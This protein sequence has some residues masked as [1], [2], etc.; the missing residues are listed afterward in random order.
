MK[1][2]ISQPRP[3]SEKQHREPARIWVWSKLWGPYWG[4]HA[5]GSWQNQDPPAAMAPDLAQGGCPL[6]QRHRKLTPEEHVDQRQDEE[7]RRAGT[8]Q[9]RWSST[10]EA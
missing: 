8:W 7:G 3:R 5:Q 1:H 2:C 4:Y 9:R 6:P 10:S